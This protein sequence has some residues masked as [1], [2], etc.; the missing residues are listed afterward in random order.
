MSTYTS[1][2]KKIYG[3]SSLNEYC[4][5]ET[6][7]VFQLSYTD[8]FKFDHIKFITTIKE[9]YFD[10]EFYITVDS[11]N[12]K[13]KSKGLFDTKRDN[14]YNLR[15]S[16]WFK[17]QINEN[18]NGFK[19]I[20]YNENEFNKLSFDDLN[21]KGVLKRRSSR[22]RFGFGNENEGVFFTYDNYFCVLSNGEVKDRWTKDEFFDIPTIFND[23][24]FENNEIFS[25]SKDIISNWYFSIH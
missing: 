15:N 2:I 14:W 12:K 24:N 3:K 10:S 9:K 4:I 19:L 16:T 11:M 25:F 13:L 20:E 5:I 6:G 7:K 22:S 23:V 18:I 17:L 1:K 8:S 21:V